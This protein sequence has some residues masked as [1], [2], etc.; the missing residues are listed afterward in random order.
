MLFLRDK[1]IRLSG[2]QRQRLGIARAL[3]NKPDVLVL[4][5]ATS[6]LDGETEQVVM[7]AVNNLGRQL[8]LVVI[9]HRLST[10]AEADI[11]YKLEKGRLHSQGSYEVM[12]KSIN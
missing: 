9:A 3:Y 5:E 4:D 11:V 10:L 1:G 6:A 12:C 7:D 2:G 8:T